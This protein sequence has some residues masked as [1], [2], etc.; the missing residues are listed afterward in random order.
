MNIE[1]KQRWIN[2]LRSG[3]YKQCYSALKKE[4]CF[5][6]VGVLCD[7]LKNELNAEWIPVS[8]WDVINGDVE[9]FIYSKYV[10][11]RPGMSFESFYYPE[12]SFFKYCGVTEYEGLSNLR[13]M[14]KN[15]RVLLNRLN[16][17]HK[18]S[19]DELADLIEENL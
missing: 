9:Y 19:F 7:I 12:N 6:V 4:D 13:V 1:I 5:C 17:S 3:N 2:A 11:D 16:D 10:V 8:Y 18:L 14:Y 15:S